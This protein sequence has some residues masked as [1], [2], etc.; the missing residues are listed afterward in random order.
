M[1]TDQETWKAMLLHEPLPKYKRLDKNGHMTQT[2]PM[3]LL[4]HVLNEFN[5]F[6]YPP[7]SK[8]G[9]KCKNLIERKF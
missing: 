7:N 6:H 2:E 8:G 9:I 5:V 3:I 1:G 4:L